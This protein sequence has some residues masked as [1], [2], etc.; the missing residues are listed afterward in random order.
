M[1]RWFTSVLIILLSFSAITMHAPAQ[2]QTRGSASAN[3]ACHDTPSNSDAPIKPRGQT[4]TCV[5]CIA[6]LFESFAVVE[7]IK[8]LFR[9]KL[10]PSLVKKMFGCADRPTT[11]PPK[12]SV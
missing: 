8:V 2:A 1:R 11:P 5:G 9:V 3:M 6:P 12:Q 7:P 4:A 10:R